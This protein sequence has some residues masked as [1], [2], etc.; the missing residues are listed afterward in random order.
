MSQLYPDLFLVLSSYT[1]PPFPIICKSCSFKFSIIATFIVTVGALATYRAKSC[2]ADFSC[3]ET[4]SCN[5]DNFLWL[6]H[7]K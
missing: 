4:I 1:D 6:T 7:I 2:S 3:P 5:C